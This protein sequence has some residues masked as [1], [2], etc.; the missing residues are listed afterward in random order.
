MDADAFAAAHRAEWNRLAAL[1]QRRRQLTGAEIDE[2]VSS[3][4][5]ASTHLSVL[6]SGGRDAALTARLSVL[7]G[8]AR[9][10]VT[11]AHTPTWRAVGEFA[12]ISFPAMAYRARW[13]WLGTTAASLAFAALLGRWIASSP[14]VQASLASHSQVANLVNH[15][16]RDYYSQNTPL[17]FASQIWTNN[18]LSAAEALILGAFLGVGTVLVLFLNMLNL[19]IDSGLMIGHGKAAEF[20]TLILPHGMLELSAVFLAAA[21][22]LRLGWAI[23][24]PG[25]RRRGQALAE[26]GRAAVTIALGLIVV[27]A[28]SGAIEAFV[29]PS[30]LSSWARIGIG[31]VAEVAFVAYVILAGHRAQVHGHSADIAQAPA[32][33]PVRG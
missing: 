16:F 23:I 5:A 15:Q 1:V 21:T 27:L 17:S 18:A 4:Q 30:G 12:V 20:F 6:R 29:T 26:E 3:Y 31:S 24:D 7:L 19:G 8:R 32:H 22:G 33:V 9:A 11:G 10:T 2:L 28:V 13:W 14:V 25:P